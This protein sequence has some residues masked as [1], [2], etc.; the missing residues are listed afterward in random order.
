MRPFAAATML[1]FALAVAPGCQRD[2]GPEVNYCR[3]LI[4]QHQTLRVFADVEQIELLS[5]VWA[6][7]TLRAALAGR[8]VEQAWWETQADFYRFELELVAADGEWRLIRAD[9]AR[10]ADR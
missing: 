7:A 2:V 1:I 9:W 3:F 6:R 10:S 8:E 4:L 5:P